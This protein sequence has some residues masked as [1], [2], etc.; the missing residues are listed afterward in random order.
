VAKASTANEL[1]L[2]VADVYEV[3]G[4][5]RASGERLAGQVGQT[6]ARWQVLS[7]A[8]EGTWTVPAIAARLGVS[9]QAVQRVTDDLVAATLARYVANPAHKRSSLVQ[10]TQ[11]GRSTLEAITLSSEGW[12]SR[13]TEALTAG[14]ISGAR[15]TLRAL[16]VAIRETPV[17]SDD[18]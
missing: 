8:S 6:Q 11:E 4:A 10:L 7:V 17:E 2:L 5:L 16:L 9:R 3:A 1:A 15:E 13:V 14:D 18:R 12:R